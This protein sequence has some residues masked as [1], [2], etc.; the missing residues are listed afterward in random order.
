MMMSCVWLSRVV[1][2]LGKLRTCLVFIY[3]QQIKALGP[4]DG[5]PCRADQKPAGLRPALLWLASRLFAQNRGFWHQSPKDCPCGMWR[6]LGTNNSHFG[7][8]GYPY[9]RSL[10]TR[11]IWQPERVISRSLEPWQLSKKICISDNGHQ[12]P[13]WRFVFTS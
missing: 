8:L 3:S 7:G 11:A 6:S 5:Q 1:F 10:S 9:L 4:E 2:R 13:S 12:Q